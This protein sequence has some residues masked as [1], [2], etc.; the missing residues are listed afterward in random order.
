MFRYTIFF[1]LVVSLGCNIYCGFDYYEKL[2]NRQFGEAFVKN[3]Q[4]K[5]VSKKEGNSFLFS[6]IKNSYSEKLNNKKYY[7]LSIWNI[8]CRPCIKEMPLLDTLADNISR[9]DIGYIFLTE[10]GESIIN[11]F[12]KKHNINSR[13]F[14]YIND[15]DIYISSILESH[16]L[17]NR[18]YP[19]QL[20]ID[21]EGNI[22]YFQ[23]GAFESSK[24]SPVIN[25][26]K[27]LP[28]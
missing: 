4:I 13:N 28:L 5:K 15:A 1:V 16:N 21:N 25:C 20:I 23:L 27:K 8:L 22:K 3:S 11:E 26:A 12:R 14:N 6:K 7:F 19:I 2:K 9:K 24:D 10:N 17:K 18:V